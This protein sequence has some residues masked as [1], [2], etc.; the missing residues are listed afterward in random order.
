MDGERSPIFVLCYARSGSTLLRY[1]LDSHPEVCAPPELHLLRA[2][3]HLLWLFAHLAATPGEKIDRDQSNHFAITSTR[4]LLSDVMNG[5]ATRCG[6]RI[7]CEKS[8]LTVAHL[9][10]LHSL[11]PDARLICLHRHPLDTIASCVEAAN[12]RQGVFGFEPYVARTPDR[13]LDG[14]ADYWIDKT[15]RILQCEREHPGRCLR[16][17]Y[18]DLV[19]DSGSALR[20]LFGFLKLAWREDLEER[21]FSTAHVVGAGDR[22]I[23]HTSRIEPG[24]VGRGQDLPREA[25]SAE[26]WVHLSALAREIG[27]MSEASSESSD[28]RKLP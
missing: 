9:A 25:L 27:Y 15:Q 17:R 4:E 5:Y 18:E 16:M 28:V 3:P 26:R 14:L 19:R 20:A 24:S 21:V 1:V 23:L 12:S 6:K 10:A 11:F 22:K 8:V 7:W 13:P 2:S